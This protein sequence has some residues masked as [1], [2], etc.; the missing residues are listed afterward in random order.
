MRH[1]LLHFHGASMDSQITH[2]VR[3]VS[4]I[5]QQLTKRAATKENSLEARQSRRKLLDVGSSVGNEIQAV[6]KWYL[7]IPGRLIVQDLKATIDRVIPENGMEA[8]AYDFF[9]PQHIK[10]E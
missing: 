5:G 9:I 8:I 4:E 1:V 6:K 2:Y 10:G 3:Q 7:N